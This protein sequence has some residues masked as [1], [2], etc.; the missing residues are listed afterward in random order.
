MGG[1]GKREGARRSVQKEG[2]GEREK[3]QERKMVRTQICAVSGQGLCVHRSEQFFTKHASSCVCIHPVVHTP[4]QSQRTPLRRLS[5]SC[6]TLSQPHLLL[7][8]ATPLL[9]WLW[10]IGNTHLSPQLSP[11]SQATI[12]DSHLRL[13]NGWMN[14][15]DMATR[16]NA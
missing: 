10:K 4:I 15:R 3:G 14:T 11:V 2:N 6:K 13:L 9:C 7:C 16:E 12:L 8:Q 5:Q 1:G